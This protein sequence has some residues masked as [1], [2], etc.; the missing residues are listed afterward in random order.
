MK[1]ASDIYLKHICSLDTS[2]FIAL[3]VLDD[4]CDKS[5]YLLTLA[6]LKYTELSLSET[7]IQ[8]LLT[9]ITTIT[10]KLHWHYV[11]SLPH[12]MDVLADCGHSG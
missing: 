3:E 2:A 5:T 6:C 8:V 4:N 12:K 1:G 7:V 10:T 11:F 9:K